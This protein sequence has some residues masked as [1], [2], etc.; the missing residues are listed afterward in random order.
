MCDDVSH[1]GLMKENIKSFVFGIKHQLRSNTSI[2]CKIKCVCFV[3]SAK[4]A[5]EKETDPT[6]QVTIEFKK[7]KR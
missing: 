2:N 7:L 6:S 1:N 4:K 3:Y 5:D